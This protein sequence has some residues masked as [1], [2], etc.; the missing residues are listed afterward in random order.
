M[1][2][3]NKDSTAVVLMKTHAELKG[4]PPQVVYEVIANPEIRRSWDKV[5]CNFEIIEDFPE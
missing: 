5:M 3:I 1:K 4:I 2:K